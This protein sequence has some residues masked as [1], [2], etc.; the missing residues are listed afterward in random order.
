VVVVLFGVLLAGLGAHLRARVLEPGPVSGGHSDVNR[1]VTC[2]GAARLDPG[3][4]LTVAVMG[5]DLHD[6]SRRC[7]ACHDLGDHALAPHA[8]PADEMEHR[9]LQ[10]ADSLESPVD[11]SN[12]P[13]LE[14]LVAGSASAPE[15]MPC[16]RCH[17]EHRGHDADLT[18]VSDAICQTCHVTRFASLADGHP[19]FYN[20]PGGRRA[21]LDFDHALHMRRHFAESRKPAPGDC[22]DCHVPGVYG[23]KMGVKSFN[24]TCA[25]CH[26]GQIDGRD[27]TAGNTAIPVLVLPG[28][29]TSE[30]R[31]RGFD[32]GDWPAW[33]DSEISPL[34]RLLL[35]GDPQLGRDLRRLDNLDLLD[36]E[37]ASNADL[38]AVQ[39]V[40][41]A[42]KTLV[43]DILI[44][45]GESLAVRVEAIVGQSLPRS[46]I[47]NL[48]AGLPRDTLA[49]AQQEWFPKVAS[50][51]AAWRAGRMSTGGGPVGATAAPSR[52]APTPEPAANASTGAGSDDLLLDDGDGGGSGD[53]LLADGGGA[54]PSDELLDDSGDSLLAGDDDL[55]GGGDDLLGGGDDLLGGDDEVWDPSGEV[56]DPSAAP[57]EESAALVELPAVDPE[58]WATLGGWYRN[59]LGLYYR[60]VGHADPFMRAWLDLLALVSG[61]RNDRLGAPLFEAL[62]SKTAPGACAKCHSVDAD[63]D[64]GL[65][66]NWQ[67]TTVPD[68][69]TEFTNFSHST[70]FALPG[71]SACGGCHALNPDP[72]FATQFAHHDP[73][74]Y[75]SSFRWMDVK[76]C[77]Q[78]HVPERAGDNCTLCHSYHV[79]IRPGAAQ[80]PRQAALE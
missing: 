57:A 11:S 56:F 25:T 61:G 48:I 73:E 10:L 54:S 2:H 63:P 45:G 4:W 36:L 1:C 20:Y 60:P 39:R 77:A 14:R 7:L 72:E 9:T 31:R 22:A 33:A 51:V 47:V 64:G 40:A 37:G 32:I 69:T 29:D 80:A 71:G 67:P 55:L 65:R 21:H 75:R 79:G 43:H 17:R 74:D 3:D 49:S 16:G 30:L 26:L 62:T 50:E 59:D 24:D 15:A 53:D 68:G 42:F 76:L 19:P 38:A 6:E 70:H 34:T 44:E 78:C 5:T 41:W 27:R 52:P 66:I 12:R 46:T 35:A 18:A 23:R 8:Q 28:L 13:I 58:R